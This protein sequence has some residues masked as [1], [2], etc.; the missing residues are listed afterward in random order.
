MFHLIVQPSR[1]EKERQVV[2][3]SDYLGGNINRNQRIKHDV[4]KK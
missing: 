4:E 1:R 2:P 3:R